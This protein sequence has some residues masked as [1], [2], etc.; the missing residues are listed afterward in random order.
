M[1]KRKKT[2]NVWCIKKADDQKIKGVTLVTKITI[3]RSLCTV[4]TSRKST[5]LKWIKK[6]N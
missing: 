2:L 3:Q 4:C 6:K 5:F 1:L